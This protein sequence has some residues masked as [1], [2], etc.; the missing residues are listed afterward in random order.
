MVSKGGKKGVTDAYLKHRLNICMYVSTHSPFHWNNLHND[1]WFPLWTF[2]GRI[3]SFEPLPPYPGLV[4]LR[5]L[6]FVLLS[7]SAI[8]KPLYP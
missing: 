8:Q 7:F 2:P 6:N 3:V 1:L 4:Q 5:L